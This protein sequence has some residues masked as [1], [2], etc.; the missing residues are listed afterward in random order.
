MTEPNQ[1]TQLLSLCLNDEDAVLQNFTRMRKN[2]CRSVWSCGFTSR[3]ESSRAVLTLFKPCPDNKTNA[4]LPPVESARKCYLAMSELPALGIPTSRALGV[5]VDLP[6][7]VLLTEE[8]VPG[9]FTLERRCRAAEILA[10]LHNADL[11]GLSDGL[12]HLIRVSNPKR[13]RTTRGLVD[14]PRMLDESMPGWRDRFPKVAEE[15]LELSR[16]IPNERRESLVHGDYFSSN[17]LAAGS[18][19]MIIDWETFALGDPMW[20]L[21]F[22]VGADRGLSERE[23]E[24]T[25]EAYCRVRA[26]EKERLGWYRRSWEMSWAIRRIRKGSGPLESREDHG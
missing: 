21:G 12:Q 5:G 4:S 6:N 23:V 9:D 22:L 25:I 10:H 15:A 16:T 8:I 19:V 13:E 17:I 14:R 20:D 7:G 1:I 11:K 24:T 3:K 2:A 26:I 18:D